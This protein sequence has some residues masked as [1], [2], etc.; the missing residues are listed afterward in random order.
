MRTIEIKAYQ[1]SELSEEAKQ[2]VLESLYDLNVDHDWWDY[3]Y[4]DAK[5]VGIKIKGFGLD[6]NKGCEGELYDDA[7]TVA[8]K[9]LKEHGK[10]CET[11]K[12]AQRFLDDL[13]TLR[14]NAKTEFEDYEVNN[15]EKDER[16]YEDYDDFFGDNFEDDFDELCEEF[17]KSILSDYADMLEKEYEYLTSEEAI[18]ETIEANDYEF[19][20]NGKM[21]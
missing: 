14:D 1:F 7:E 13:A 21:I 16:E 17:E 3:I 10:A 8:E 12:T 15:P 4:D 18:I 5:N 19:D 6:R 20:E 11:Y 9:I 2:K